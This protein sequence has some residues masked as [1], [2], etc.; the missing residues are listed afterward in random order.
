MKISFNAKYRGHYF[1]LYVKFSCKVLLLLLNELLLQL[2]IT[3]LKCN[4][5]LK[6]AE[7]DMHTHSCYGCAGSDECREFCSVNWKHA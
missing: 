7:K 6:F 2:I 3:A 5:M 4:F 1:L